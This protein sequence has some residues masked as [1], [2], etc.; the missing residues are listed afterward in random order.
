MIGE[1]CKRSVDAITDSQCSGV[2][3]EKKIHI[4]S[5]VSFDRRFRYVLSLVQK[6]PLV[7]VN[8]RRACA[9]RVTVLCLFV[10]VCVCLIQHSRRQ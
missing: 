9:A 4:Q 1:V 6:L 5:F 10:T 3:E 8:P 2:R 7:V